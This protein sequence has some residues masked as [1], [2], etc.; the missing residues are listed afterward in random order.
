MYEKN[1]KDELEIE[2]ENQDRK[3]ILTKN[4]FIFAG[5]N[6]CPTKAKPKIY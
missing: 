6:I 5:V 4:N 1:P 3:I 2:R